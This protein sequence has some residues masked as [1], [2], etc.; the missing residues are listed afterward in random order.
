VWLSIH[1]S[2]D[3]LH[4]NST[5]DLSNAMNYDTLLAPNNRFAHADVGIFLF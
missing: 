5:L 2:R 4:N 1:I 3:T